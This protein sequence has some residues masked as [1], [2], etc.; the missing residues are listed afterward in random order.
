[1]ATYKIVSDT[2]VQDTL[3]R[4]IKIQEEKEPDV[5]GKP[6]TTSPI[7]FTTPVCTASDWR[8]DH[9]GGNFEVI[10][11]TENLWEDQNGGEWWQFSEFFERKCNDIIDF[12]AQGG[13]TE[14]TGFREPVN[15]RDPN[16]PKIYLKVKKTFL[17]DFL[18]NYVHGAPLRLIFK[19]NCVY[20]TDKAKGLSFELI[21]GT[22]N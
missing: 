19:L 9:S 5:G 22:C 1:M 12:V 17:K 13:I 7:L 11:V 4:I 18:S 6:F 3:L 10:E 16:S 20:V 14:K 8:T 21:S 2:T 15:R